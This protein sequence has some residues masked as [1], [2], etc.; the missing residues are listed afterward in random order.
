MRDT[1]E[2]KSGCFFIET[3]TLY[4]LHPAIKTMSYK[5]WC[6]IC[7]SCTSWS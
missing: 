7:Y 2:N 1:E 5:K 3:S 6:I 4:S